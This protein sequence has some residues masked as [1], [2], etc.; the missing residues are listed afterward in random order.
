MKKEYIPYEEKPY[1]SVEKNNEE[2]L[3]LI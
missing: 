1:V 2:N 3:Q